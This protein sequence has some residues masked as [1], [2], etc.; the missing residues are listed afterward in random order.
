[1]NN[2]L[3]NSY[4]VRKWDFVHVSQFLFLRLAPEQF[5]VTH[6][7]TGEGHSEYVKIHRKQRDVICTHKNVHATFLTFPPRQSPGDTQILQG[8][9]M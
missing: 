4:D 1:M 6:C 7:G 2:Q 9:L 3:I 8:T 5:S